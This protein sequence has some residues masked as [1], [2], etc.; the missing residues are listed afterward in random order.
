[1]YIFQKLKKKLL[2]MNVPFIIKMYNNWMHVI[3][4]NGMKK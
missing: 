3:Y 2:E 4:I 1:M